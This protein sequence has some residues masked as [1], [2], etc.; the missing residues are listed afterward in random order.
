LQC[1][2]IWSRKGISGGSTPPFHGRIITKNYAIPDWLIDLLPFISR[3][4]G[5]K[6]QFFNTFNQYFNS[7]FFTYRYINVTHNVECP[8]WSFQTRNKGIPGHYV[9]VIFHLF[10]HPMFSIITPFTVYLS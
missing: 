8:I 5:H 1:S 7:F 6:C 2:L 4:Y 10:L 9:F 3:M